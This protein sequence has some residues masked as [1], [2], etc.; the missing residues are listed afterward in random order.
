MYSDR[1]DGDSQ[2]KMTDTRTDVATLGLFRKEGVSENACIPILLLK[3]LKIML[4]LTFL[5]QIRDLTAPQLTVLQDLKS[6]SV[7][8]PNP[9]VKGNAE[10]LSDLPP[11]RFVLPQDQIPDLSFEGHAGNHPPI[12]MTAASRI[13]L[14]I[15]IA[16]RIAVLDYDNK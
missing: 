6:I 4:L 3:S 12:V 9:L 15:G 13:V 2:A 14:L 16:V 7:S 11:N 1:R 8:A 5:H 10:F